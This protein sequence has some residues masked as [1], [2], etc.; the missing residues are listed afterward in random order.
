MESNKTGVKASRKIGGERT[1]L[2]MDLTPEA[3]FQQQ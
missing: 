3:G 1:N 2:D